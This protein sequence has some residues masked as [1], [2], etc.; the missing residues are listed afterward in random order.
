MT[1]SHVFMFMLGEK[2]VGAWSGER[3]VLFPFEK[4]SQ[5]ILYVQN[6][7]FGGIR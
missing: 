5:N 2:V 3:R 7:L 4:I 1:Y 6:I